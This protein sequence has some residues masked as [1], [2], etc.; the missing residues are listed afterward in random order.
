MKYLILLILSFPLAANECR[1]IG[2]KAKE[3]MTKRQTTN[4]VFKTLDNY[5]DENY[6]DIILEAYEEPFHDTLAQLRIAIESSGS[7]SG[8][9]ERRK[10]DDIKARFDNAINQFRLKYIKI[11][12][13]NKNP[14]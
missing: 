6:E 5:R 11:C 2:D 8:A 10:F 1:D 13:Q 7:R 4:D 3:I 12:I 14:S 9:D